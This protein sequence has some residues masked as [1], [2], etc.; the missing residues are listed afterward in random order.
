M[1]T[2]CEKTCRWPDCP[3]LYIEAPADDELIAHYLAHALDMGIGPDARVAS[4]KE[5]SQKDP[6][7]QSPRPQGPD[8]PEDESEG[9]DQDNI[10]DRLRDEFFRLDFYC[11]RCL[12]KVSGGNA[13]ACRVSPPPLRRT[14]LTEIQR[15]RKAPCNVIGHEHWAIGTAEDRKQWQADRKNGID[16][17]T[18]TGNTT[19]ATSRA[20][21]T[22][23]N[24][25]PKKTAPKDSTYKPPPP[26][27]D[28]PEE[29]DLVASPPATRKVKGKSRGKRKAKDAGLGGDDGLDAGDRGD[30]GDRDERQ[31]VV[32][33]P[34][35]KQKN[36]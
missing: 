27:D 7:H 14:K 23:K 21:R 36:K 34:A 16:P 17:F 4:P 9:E 35:K 13:S 1:H 6:G 33:K 10:P 18:G 25:T 30:A 2:H 22:P 5:L 11:P 8:A 32:T 28:E 24:P 12:H 20:A 26:S 19:G 31:V 29:E 3:T 15:H